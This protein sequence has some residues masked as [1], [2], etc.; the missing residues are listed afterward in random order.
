MEERLHFYETGTTPRKNT[1]VMKEA[2][3]EAKAVLVTAQEGI[4]GGT[5]VS[6]KKKKKKKR[7][8]ELEESG[9]VQTQEE[10][11][12]EEMETES[13]AAS[14]KKKKKHKKSLEAEA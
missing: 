1:D 13:K 2:I 9:L 3:A 5:G 11:L 8:S 6:E 7:V 4:P 14:A 10:L 12:V